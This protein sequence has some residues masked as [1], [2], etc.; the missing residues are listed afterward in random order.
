MTRSRVC[1]EPGCR[2]RTRDG[3]AYC[4]DHVDRLGYAS[5]L[6]P[7]VAAWIAGARAARLAKGEE[8]EDQDP[9]PPPVVSR[10][11]APPPRPRPATRIPPTRARAHDIAKVR[12]HVPL[13][14]SPPCE[15]C[16]RRI[17]VL[18]R[19]DPPR[20]RA[21]LCPH[22]RT[23]AWPRGVRPTAHPCIECLLP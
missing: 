12:Q 5:D 23:C 17:Q 11:P 21:H 20:P 22:G 9:E 3:K 8:A 19:T 18:R 13:P 7:K 15:R 14:S 2:Q 4:P 16:G 1:E 10:A 6:L